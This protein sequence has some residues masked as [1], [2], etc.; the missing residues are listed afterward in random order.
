MIFIGEAM[1]DGA[2]ATS[3]SGGGFMSF[4]PMLF[5]I[6]V[7]YFLLIRPQQ[8]RSKQH[9]T[10]LASIKKGDKVVTNSGIIGVVT[11]VLNDQEVMI[12]I[13]EKVSVK[14]IKSTIST[15]L[16][17]PGSTTQPP[18]DSVAAQELASTKPTGTK[19]DNSNSDGELA[20][21]AT[22]SQIVATA[23]TETVV[24]QEEKVK[25]VRRYYPRRKNNQDN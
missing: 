12:E 14:F 3:S 13:A 9:Q 22:D 7:I 21:A 2:T 17:Q 16:P 10:L 25:R 4:L 5:F 11:K 6:G 24:K 20:Q 18:K 19:L 15:L 23:K 8:K 1:A